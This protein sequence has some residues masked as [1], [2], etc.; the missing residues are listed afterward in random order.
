MDGTTTDDG[1]TTGSAA[2]RCARD[3]LT[4]FTAVTAVTLGL[5]LTNPWW[6]VPTAATAF[7][8]GRRPG[9]T[10]PTVLALAAVLAAGVTAL[11]VVPTWLP[12]ADRFVA[13]VV[14]AAMLPWFAGRFWCQYRQLARAGWERA[15]QLQRE[16]R[17]VAEQARSRE[18]AR[19]AQDMHDVLGH[20]L[21][22][23]ALSAGALKLAPDQ[24]DGSR[25]CGQD[26]R[27]AE[28]PTGRDLLP[29]FSFHE[30]RT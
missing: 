13:V 2:R 23:I 7:L 5:S 30:A 12:L 3:P 6:T 19:I 25:S 15:D 10:G 16:R 27:G 4:Y 8:S 14:G 9:R 11:S 29:R 24:R 21:S 1:T 28:R 22:L 26:G 17:L 18:R 20:D